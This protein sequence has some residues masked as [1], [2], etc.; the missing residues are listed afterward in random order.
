MTADIERIE[1]MS[2]LSKNGKEVLLRQV[3]KDLDACNKALEALA[4]PESKNA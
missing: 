2:D 4:K 3:K 1:K